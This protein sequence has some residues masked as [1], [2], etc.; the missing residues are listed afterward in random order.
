VLEE[1]ASY[2]AFACVYLLSLSFSNKT[3]QVAHVSLTKHSIAILGADFNSALTH[4]MRK[5]FMNFFDH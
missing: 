5:G 4:L 1:L 3:F 2:G